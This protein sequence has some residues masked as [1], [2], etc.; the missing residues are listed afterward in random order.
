[1][2]ERTESESRK[3]LRR[4]RDT[5]AEPGA[6]Q[7]RLDRITHLIADSMRTEVCSIYLFRD[8]DTLEL[9]ATEGLKKESVHQTRMRL[10]EGLVGRVAKTLTPINTADAPA[11]K[12]FRYMPET[13]EEIYSSFLGV[14]IQRLGEKLGVLVVQSKEAR[15]YSDDEVYAIEVVAMV[16]AEMT[17]LGAFIGEGEALSA[18]HQQPV[19]FRGA[20]G[21]EG[22]AI[23][24]VW[25]HEPR[26]VITNPVADDPVRE[27]ERLNEAVGRLRLSVDA[28]VTMTDI[29]DKEQ[30]QVLEAYRMFANSRGWMRRMEEDIARGLSAEAAVEKEQSAA[31]AR[32][33]TVPDPYL[34]DRLHDLDDLSN[35]LLRILTGQGVDTGAELP[36]NPIL[37]ARNIGPAELLDYGR[38]LKGVVLEEGSVGSHAAIVARALAIPLVIH[39]EKITTEALNGDAILVDGD[40]GIVHLRPEDTVAAAFRDKIAMQAAAQS[41]YASLRDKP[42]TALCGTTVGLHM[43]AGLMA[44]LPSLVGS[45]AEGV[46]LFRTELQFLIRNH[47]PKRAELARIYSGVLDA[48]KGR[49]VAFRTLDI[50]SDKVLPYMKRVEEPNPAMGWR[51]IRVGLDKPGVMRM[52]L[53]ALLRGAAGRP[54][55]LMFPFVA[56]FDEFRAAR[57]ML[58]D[59][60]KRERNLGHVLPGALEIGAMLETPSLAYAPDAFFDMADFISIGGNDLK[61]FFFAADRENER[62]RRRYDVLNASFLTFIRAIV[63]RCEESKTAL[64]FCGEDAG[65]PVEALCL[66]ALGVPTLSMRPSSIGPV[67]HLIRHVNLK[68]LGKLI[69]TE[70][71][72]GTTNLREPVLDWLSNQDI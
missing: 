30:K 10:G 1:M 47:V 8:D 22:A 67:K 26:V 6:G 33:E 66:A 35:R 5:L 52:Q 13:G 56:E 29:G 38:K 61:Q 55:T 31:R 20:T 16:V 65:R 7:E 11:E 63:R 40:Q 36:E 54:L 43:N 45:G 57:Q 50:G 12:G 4:L 51:A 3:L 72:A 62:V 28:M 60:V 23:G 37:V 27:M 39:A 41:R 71:D 14:P 34:R 18:L 15:A 70:I 17:E 25:L 59:E 21:Q 2:S 49:R 9:C 19:M 58:L 68:E 24:R 64:S 48:A 32:L 46:G 42:A 53:Q 44:D 69:E